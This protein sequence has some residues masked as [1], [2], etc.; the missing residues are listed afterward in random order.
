MAQLEQAKANLAN[1]TN[2]RREQVIIA[3]AQM[4]Q[5]R[6]SLQQTRLRLAQASLV[7]PQERTL[8]FDGTLLSI[9]YQVGD[10]AAPG[11][12][13]IVLADLRQL[14]TACAL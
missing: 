12:P 8:V 9:D 2:P 1:L 4:Q 14:H 6:L 3:Q 5:A 7:A 11:R 13:A 10:S